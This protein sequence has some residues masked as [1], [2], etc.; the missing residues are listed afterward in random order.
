MAISLVTTVVGSGLAVRAPIVTA[1]SR[2]DW[3]QGRDEFSVSLTSKA[4]ES[5]TIH[6]PSVRF[7][8]SVGA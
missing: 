5:M 1:L 7:S 2:A 8:V 4:R 3:Y 6:S